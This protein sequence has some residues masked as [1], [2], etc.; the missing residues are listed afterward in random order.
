MERTRNRRDMSIWGWTLL[1]GCVSGTGDGM[2]ETP[3]WQ[4][5]DRAILF[6]SGK[7]AEAINERITTT[8]MIQTTSVPFSS[9][10]RQAPVF[11]PTPLL[12]L[13]AFC[14]RF[15]DETMRP[16]RRAAMTPGCVTSSSKQAGCPNSAN[17]SSA[18][19]VF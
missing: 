18:S 4:Q 13:P 9:P 10:R 19:S 3:G 12:R 7:S 15:A 1:S 14:C 5:L 6:T 17:P 2:G 11:A 8:S 16:T